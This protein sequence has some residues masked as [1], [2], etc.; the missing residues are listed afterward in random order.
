[1]KNARRA[2]VPRKARARRV[3]RTLTQG[4]A[5]GVAVLLALFLFQVASHVHA[6][7]RNQSACNRC[8]LAHLGLALVKKNTLLRVPHL[9][10]GRIFTFTP[11]FH[12]V[13][14]LQF[15]SSRAPPSA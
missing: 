6:N 8:Q 10:V 5:L 2:L 15:S 14:F 13:L 12:Q 9:A 1:M 7:D 11:I 4:L 3:R